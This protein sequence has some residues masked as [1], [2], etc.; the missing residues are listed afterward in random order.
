MHVSLVFLPASVDPP[1]V[2][3]EVPVDVR[4]TTTEFDQIVIS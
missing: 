4:M 2:G 1:A 3:D